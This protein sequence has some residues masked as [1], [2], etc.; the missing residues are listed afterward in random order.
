MRKNVI[1]NKSVKLAGLSIFN[2][3]SQDQQHQ[4]HTTATAAVGVGSGSVA[5]GDTE[6]YD[7]GGQAEVGAMEPKV[8]LSS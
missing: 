7:S 2:G 8:A 3:A 1:S 4:Q 6:R 5:T